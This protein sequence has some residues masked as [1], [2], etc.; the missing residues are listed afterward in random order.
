MAKR[1]SKKLLMGLG[2]AITFG[3]VGTVSGFGLKSI[4]DSVNEQNLLNN[5]INKLAEAD[6]DRAPDYNKATQDMFFDTTNLKSFHFGNVQ[7][8]QSIT[9]YGWL[10]VFEQP[11][12][13][14]RKIALTGWNGEI[15]WVNDDYANEGNNTEFNV[16]DM[17]Y[18]FNTDLVFVARTSSKNGLINDNKSV[19]RITIDVLDAKLGIKK[20]SV[21]FN[22]T[23]AWNVLSGAYIDSND[24]NHLERSRNLYS[25]DV[26]S[27][28][29]NAV[30]LS[31]TPNFLQLTSRRDNY[32]GPWD[33][34]KNRIMPMYNLISN[35]AYS[36]V[37]TNLNFIKNTSDGTVS[38]SNVPWLNI[39]DA[40]SIQNTLQPGWFVD[41]EW[42]YLHNF[43]LITN[44]FITTN[45]GKLMVH[46][47][48]ANKH[49]ATSNPKVYH[50][51]VEFEPNGKYI[52]EVTENITSKIPIFKDTT[53]IV[54]KDWS[55]NFINANLKINR[56]MFDNNSIVFAFPYAAGGN[57]R[58]PI[59]NVA[60]L[61]I[62]P[63]DGK[64]DWS[65]NK[66]AKKSMILPMGKDIVEYW[67]KNNGSYGSNNTL[68]KIYPFPGGDHNNLNHNYNR[69]ITVSPFDNTI[70]YAAKPNLTNSIFDVTNNYQDKWAGFWLG[71]VSKSTPYRPFL[72]YN[73]SNSL[74]GVIDPKMTSINDLYTYG[75]T[76]DLR[77]LTGQSLNLYFNQTG[78]GRN[79]RYS[80]SVF[81]SS[82]IGLLTD[83]LS[84]DR[85]GNIWF[86]NVTNPTSKPLDQMGSNINDTSYSTLIYSR[87]NLE[88]WYP[89]TWLNNETPGNLFSYNQQLNANSSDNSRAVARKF[90]STLSESNL[91]NSNRSVDLLS[92]WYDKNNKAPANYGRLLVKRPEIRVRNES[93]ANVLPVEVVYPFNFSDF[94]NSNIWIKSL[95]NNERLKFKFS[96]NLPTASYQIFSSWKNQ[97]RMNG[98]GSDTKNLNASEVH[99]LPGKPQPTWYD[100][101]QQNASPNPFGNVNNDVQVNGKYPLRMLLR[102][103]KPSGNLPS[104][105][106]GLE[107][108]KLFDKYPL[109]KD[110][111]TGETTFE[112][113]LKKFVEEKTKAIDVGQEANNVAVGLA[114]LKIEAFADLNPLLIGINNKTIYK[115]GTKR[116]IILNDQGQRIIYED[117]YD[118][119]WRE[120]YDQSATVYDEFNLYGFGSRV[121]SDVQTSWT[122]QMPSENTKFKVVVNANLLKDNLVRKSA[123]EQQLFTF[124]YETG[125]QNLVITPKDASW[126]RPRL[127]N[128]QRLINMQARFEYQTATNGT[129]QTLTTTTDKKM[130]EYWPS[131][132]TFKLPTS[133]VTGITKLRIKLIPMNINS[134]N[135]SFVQFENYNEA[136]PDN[137]FISIPQ[138]S[139]VQR[140]D[141]DKN[142]FNEIT[143]TSS[144]FLQ[145][146]DAASFEQYQNT[147]LEKSKAIK[148]NP[149]LK[150]QIKLVYQWPGET[151]WVD[152]NSIINTIKGK[153]NFN[154]G[155]WTTTDQGVWSLF[156][157]SNSTNNPV[158]IKV[159]FEK[160]NSNSNIQFVNSTNASNNDLTGELR[161]TVKTKVDLSSWLDELRNLKLQSEGNNSGVLT[162]FV[163]PGKSGTAGQSQFSG[164]TYEQ[165]I[166]IL[167]NV[168]VS[169]RFKKW[170]GSAW[171][172]WLTNSTEVNSYNVN[173]PEIIIGFTTTNSNIELKDTNS[174]TI[175]DNT[176]IKLK[177]SLPKIVKLPANEQTMIVEYNK[178]NPFSGNTFNLGVDTTKLNQAQQAVLTALK[179][180][181]QGNNG[182]DYSGLDAVLEFKYKL[183]NSTFLSATELQKYL[184]TQTSTDQT[185]NALLLKVNIKTVQGQEPEFALDQ[186]LADKEFQ[187]QTDNN[188]SIKKWLHGKS[189]E[190]ELAKNNISVTG[191]KSN[192]VYSL[193]GELAKFTKANNG[194][195]S[196]QQLTLQYQ[197]IGPNDQPVGTWT[198]GYMPETVA[199]NINK[200]KVRIVW[201]QAVTTANQIYIYGPQDSSTPNQN[202]STIDLSR[203]ATLVKIDPAWFNNTLIVNTRT[204][205][206]SLTIQN[207]K[208]WEN[209]IY[210]NIAE[211]T[212]PAIRSKIIIKYQFGKHLN[213]TSDNLLNA[214][215]NIELN[216]YTDSEHHGIIKL[217]DKNTPNQN[218]YKIKATFEK[219]TPNDPTIQFV[220]KTGTPIDGDN[221]KNLRTGDV[222]TTN[223]TTTLDLTAWITNLINQPT[224][225]ETQSAGTINTGGLKPPSLA[226]NALLGNNAKF[227]DLKQWLAAANINLLWSKTS[228]GSSGWQSSDTINEY[229]PTKK[230]LWFAIEN[231]ASNLILKLG[232]NH[233]DLTP[234]TNNKNNPFEIK[235][236]APALINIHP[237]QLAV[238]AQHIS[239]N[240]KQLNVNVAEITKQLQ[241]FKKSLGTGFEDAPLTINL[242]VGDQGPYDYKNIAQKLLEWPD[243]VANGI[244][245]ANFAIDT[246]QANASKFELTDSSK[247]DQQIIND[248]GTIKV[249][250]NDKNILKDLKATTPQGSSK[251]LKLSWQNGISIDPQSGVLIAADRG[252]GL[253]IE[254]TFRTDLQG[255]DNDVTNTDPT[256]G[257]SK[258][259][260]TSFRSGVDKSLFIRIRLV[261]PT[262]YVYDNLNQKITIDLTKL[263][264]IISLD[265]R[266]LQK[267]VVANP[268]DASGFG[269]TQI[270]NYEN[271]VF[272]A[273]QIPDTL[274]QQIM[275]KYDFN[276]Q[277]NVDK[278]KLNELITSYKTNNSSKQSLGILQFAN[279]TETAN[280]GSLSEKIIAKFTLK[281]DPNPQYELEFTNG[282]NQY[283]LD[284]SKVITTIDF[285][286][287]LRW[288]Q[289]IKVPFENNR[290]NIPNINTQDAYFNG[291]TW[292]KTEQALKGFGITIEYRSVLD[293]NQNPEA[294]WSEQITSVNQ[295]N[296]QIGKFQ[297]RFKFDAKKS[298]NTKFKVNNTDYNGATANLKTPA[299]DI[300]LNV[301]LN[302]QINGAFVDA[303]RTT[304]NV[305]SGNTKYLSILER[306]EAKMLESIKN[307]N[308]LNNQ[309]FNDLDLTVEY[310]IGEAQAGG[311]WRKRTEFIDFLKKTNTDQVTNKI[312]FRFAINPQQQGQFSVN[313]NNFYTLSEK[314]LVNVTNLA[315]KY[316]VHTDQRE[317]KANNVN[318][319][320]SQDQLQWD[321]STFGQANTNFQELNGE[322]FLR[323]AAGGLLRLEFT[324][325]TNPS[326]SDRAASNDVNNLKTQWVTKKPLQI[327]TDDQQKLFIRIKPINNNIVYEADYRD[328]TNNVS[329]GQ[330]ADVHKVQTRIQTKINIDK[331]WLNE[332]TL[333]EQNQEIEIKQFNE[334]LINK[335]IEKLR[336][337]I[338]VANNLADDTYVSKIKIE[339]TFDGSQTKLNATGL[340][341]AISTKLNDYNSAELGIFHLWNPNT[342]DGIKINATFTTDDRNII[343]VPANNAGLSDTL[344]TSK[345]YTLIDFNKYATLLETKPTS[346]VPTQNGQPGDIS[347]FEPPAMDGTAGSGFLA[348]KNYDEI[349]ARLK[350]EG[351]DIQFSKS[352]NGPWSNKDQINS[353]NPKDPKLFLSFSNRAN[354]NV[355][356]NAK[357]ITVTPG[358]SNQ[359]IITLTLKAPKL[360]TIDQAAVDK[361]RQNSGIRGNTKNLEYNQ[362]N[363]DTLINEIKRAASNNAI[364]GIDK[365][366]LKVLF[367]LGDSD[368]LEINQLVDWLKK[369]PTDQSNNALIL[370]FSIP[371]DQAE[372]WII[373]PANGTYT[374]YSANNTDIPIFVNDQG[375]FNA[376]K[377]QT[378]IT[379]TNNNLNWNFPTGEGFTIDNNDNFANNSTK[380][381]GLK[382]EFTTNGN[383]DINA[384]GWT[385]R[386]TNVP[387]GTKAIYIKIIAQNNQYIYQKTAETNNAKIQI[388]LDQIREQIN[389]DS[390]WLMKDFI[391]TLTD[392]KSVNV[393][394]FQTYEQ[395]VINEIPGLPNVTKTKLAIKYYFNGSKDPV[396][397]NQLVNLIQNYQNQQSFNILQLSNGTNGLPIVAT[398]VKADENGLY[399]LI[400][401]NTDPQKRN[402]DTSKVTTTIEFDKAISWLT[403][404]AT[405]IEIENVNKP[406]KPNAIKI[407]LK[408]ISANGDQV[409]NNK[410]WSTTEQVLKSFGIITEYRALLKSNQNQP[411]QGWTT[412]LTNVDEYDP[413]IGKFQ[414]RFKFDNAKASNMKFKLTS[415]LTVNGTDTNPTQPFD[416]QLKIKLMVEINPDFVLN[417]FISKPNVISGNTKV[418]AIDS[419]LE[420]QMVQNIKNAN[421]INNNA[422][423]D[424]KLEVRYQLGEARIGDVWRTR[425]EFIDFLNDATDDQITN[426]VVFKF[427]IS[428]DQNQEFG[429]VDTIYTLS[430]F[431]SATDPNLKIKY[432]INSSNWEDKASKL[433]ITGTSDNL[434]WNFVDVFGANKFEESNGKVYVKT[435][436]GLGLQLYFT[437]NDNA[438]Y[439]NPG[440]SDQ[441]N[442]IGSKW[443]SIKP[444]AINAGVTN[445]KVKL[446]ANQGY[447]YG[448]SLANATPKAQ[449]HNVTIS[450]QKVLYVDRNWFTL[451]PI[452]NTQ[453]D[454]SSLNYQKH[455]K[456]WEDEVYKQLA[457]KNSVNDQIARKIKI[458]YFFEDQPNEKFEANDLITKINQLRTDYNNADLGILQ[459]WNGQKGRKLNAIFESGEPANY[460]IRVENV[461]GEPAI[462]LI[463]NQLNTEN[464]FTTISLVKYIKTLMQEKTT[465]IIDDPNRPGS[466]QSF[467]PPDG[468]NVNEIFY[469]KSYDQIAARLQATGV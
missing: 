258:I 380:G 27:N 448:P 225:I 329:P 71:T 382:L 429:V 313:Q 458:K 134:D 130:Q 261:E 112:D 9:P 58:V 117:K 241:Q 185:S 347:S 467:N 85:N 236:D 76:F 460:A 264:S 203:I 466:I 376:I 240:T 230:K 342:N 7:K 25:L 101:R 417:G 21:T 78:T 338:K 194:K 99:A 312:V 32:I 31:W 98:I 372:N 327:A 307:E 231:Q 34:T 359:A 46:L 119:R 47:L 339:F 299:F 364:V 251:N 350:V 172:N 227:N 60:Q 54:S 214:I 131:G 361:F 181:S 157:G 419:T 90:D 39:R 213:L 377:D 292:V 439:E 260:P 300:N 208:D 103:A 86:T 177:L 16:Y 167:Q 201:D 110:A 247:A 105:F 89:K 256:Q 397:K 196:Q 434:Q 72:V 66:G 95:N 18:D 277:T 63:S 141:V 29:T 332:I 35:N 310:Q 463:K 244:V 319:S 250:I 121:R 124:D 132:N 219:V 286:N 97:M 226:T 278:T 199:S 294:N 67:Q 386:I 333:T 465:V 3:A 409:F 55:S 20:Q 70:I 269:L 368:F 328:P 41:N 420:N 374:V 388:N 5:Q 262:K 424:L 379:G 33:N 451:N 324:T 169:I 232:N 122:N 168:G 180:S 182:S 322:V 111:V 195:Y 217:Y 212:D 270:T 94:L 357:N 452:V 93:I 204:D 430:D 126:L 113:V 38:T 272:A 84:R 82:K 403:N 184:K 336:N 164:K 218:G 362:T 308:I 457:K 155:N 235:L 293:L 162:R 453:I 464:I 257:W 161:S 6:F 193:S 406:G 305:V 144:N 389:V 415:G 363:I 229:D 77:S 407:L 443:V 304:P 427:T 68:N 284:T 349:A 296:P 444:N 175:S 12:S 437:T 51:A 423:K 107:Q 14:S 358:Q 421:M 276:G 426:K 274:K 369:Q 220:N 179:Q 160:V 153:L 138:E 446:V 137:K 331:N 73:D 140:V 393:A 43:S 127:L 4:I 352:S 239:G 320:G 191:S 360:I 96:Q 356:L 173:N 142:W 128:F 265:T 340:V 255:A 17:K 410:D 301:K 11:N 149:Q 315:I 252:R 209:Q 263:K 298:K 414:I 125:N 384:S 102:I 385:R 323:S 62:N 317:N 2:S 145:E 123:S 206:K 36:A 337:K 398:F 375:I 242:K 156:N 8:G 387:L 334:E 285:N 152:H 197:L 283:Q 282:D 344:N 365:A 450:I 456:P 435:N 56:N 383:L 189:F 267:T 326:Y 23:A 441:A 109:A 61:L 233:Q 400:Y 459:L 59:F 200:I 395:K 454:I 100:K 461:A 248:N 146:I 404:P 15:L 224:V 215:N 295:Y 280:D 49:D 291:Q 50:Q 401:A 106:N 238:I 370:K 394:N 418:L 45:A 19:A 396:D 190:A 266:W 228:D 321:F 449:A 392:I 343:L 154:P 108:Q 412:N 1:I 445:L 289:S 166:Q 91:F 431:K 198:D 275:I 373:S 79:D 432:F 378:T 381:K 416:V 52:K 455:L 428:A 69:L 408:T 405:K 88:K 413:G 188:T 170:Q 348:G 174:T 462:D 163:I 37:V 391:N 186:A 178:N 425:Q 442:E 399:D 402:L 187:L 207:I 74:G 302:V 268:T 22:Q 136:N 42:E 192:L 390:S 40:D 114:N 10:G 335:W 205:S 447:I 165:I 309:A 254:Y 351:I 314:Q 176:E 245:V 83:V 411:N 223:I 246:T 341:N 129:W 325:K 469:Q 433:K 139:G 26:I 366:P 13:I 281:T 48:V 318:V 316:F 436:A 216:N 243:D 440:T 150:S 355:H 222:N 80:N 422:F 210:Q 148:A 44:P 221:N 211:A 28:G 290:I 353:Y 297:I 234:Q 65:A 133:N 81:L 303:F 143:L 75:P 279:G 183:G 104:W 147:I 237:N 87:A 120:V 64:I 249:Y 346:V 438:T 259:L 367:K 118:E 57:P 330:Q 202:E 24:S 311:T 171:S 288:L 159:K 115:N 116:I 345:I 271:S 135:N 151:T 273:M 354:N 53:W 371:D 158:K 30:V 468:A 92:D 287:V 306:A 253:R